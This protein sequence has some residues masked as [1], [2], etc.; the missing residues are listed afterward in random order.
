MTRNLQR[1]QEKLSVSDVIMSYISPRKQPGTRPEKIFL[2][3]RHFEFVTRQ[4]DGLTAVYRSADS[5]VRI[6]NPKKIQKNLKLHRKMEGA[7][8]PV[9]ALL[10]EGEKDGE[11]YFIESSL[12]DAHFGNLFAE[13]ISKVGGIHED[14][15]EQFVSVSEKFARA[16]LTTQ[17]DTRQY[18]EFAKGIWLDQVCKELPEYADRVRARFESVQDN[19]QEIP[20]VLT[21]GDFNPNNLY[22]AG[23][24]DLEDS[25][26][27]PYGYDQV[28]AVAHIDSFPSSNDY[29]YFA[30]YRFTL[31]QREHYM[32]RMD[33]ISKDAGLPPL[34]QC[35]DDFEFCRVIWLAADIPNTPKLQKFRYDLLIQ[36]IS[37]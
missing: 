32:Q 27:A 5:Y 20:F 35:A 16:Q 37:S 8:F 11:A 12:G 14:L 31:T 25:F 23:V 13:S 29:E 33:S 24:I 22:P 21:H 10:A 3:G 1:L 30:K 36:K 26:Y 15:F 2:D 6:G 28:S 9:A 17:V 18:E 34:S 19:T 4:R 7:G